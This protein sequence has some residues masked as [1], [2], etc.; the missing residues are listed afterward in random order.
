MLDFDLIKLVLISGL[1]SS[2]ITTATVQKIKENLKSKKY[3]CLI[4]FI[5]SMTIGTLFSYS[6]SDL[7]LINDLWA[8]FLTFIGADVIYKAFEEKI[9]KPF[10]E[11]KKVK[12]LER[13][14]K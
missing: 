2:V 1:A 10:S 6:F 3:I 8:G 13:S 5:I 14:G 7:S 9:F 12:K 11:I 4:S